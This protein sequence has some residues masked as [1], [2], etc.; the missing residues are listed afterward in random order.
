MYHR[1]GSSHPEAIR[2]RP[3][4]NPHSEEAARS[5]LLL[6]YV[7]G[8]THY[9]TVRQDIFL[10]IPKKSL[11]FFLM[12]CKE[13]FFSVKEN[14]QK[15]RYLISPVCGHVFFLASWVTSSSGPLPWNCSWCNSGNIKISLGN[16]TAQCS[17]VTR[18]DLFYLQQTAMSEM[19]Q[20]TGRA[21]KLS[22]VCQ[23][24]QLPHAVRM[25]T[26]HI[27]HIF[28]YALHLF[29]CGKTDGSGYAHQKTVNL[30]GIPSPQGCRGRAINPS[31]WRGEAPCS[32]EAPLRITLQTEGSLTRYGAP[33]KGVLG[34]HKTYYGMPR[35]RTK[36]GERK[37]EIAG[38]WGGTSAGHRTGG[39]KG[40]VTCQ[41]VARSYVSLAASRTW[42]ARRLLSSPETPFLTIFPGEGT[43]PS[44]RGQGRGVCVEV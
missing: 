1:G 7:T 23:R 15:C 19:L 31:S 11:F 16:S 20:E 25:Y 42:S 13:F 32:A 21:W 12:E 2:R 24:D 3:M 17:S 35:R 33:G 9:V 39:Q 27:P 8:V 40:L 5:S 28:C 36:A 18:K 43:P 44:A 22:R 29:N 38:G 41:A 10:F 34:L 37:R 14:Q 6:E 26:T 4:W 30:C